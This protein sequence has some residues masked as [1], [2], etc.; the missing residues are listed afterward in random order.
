VDLV[1]ERHR[2]RYEFNNDYRDQLAEKGLVFSGTSADGRLVETVEL[3][4]PSLVCCLPVP[5]SV[6][7]SSNKTISSICWLYRGCCAAQK[8]AK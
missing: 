6:Q 4:K 1:D 8:E 5:P 2:H 7:I 3:H